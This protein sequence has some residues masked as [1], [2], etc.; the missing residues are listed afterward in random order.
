MPGQRARRLLCGLS[1]GAAGI[2][3]ALLELFAA[4]GD[5]RFAAAGHGAF[6]Y[7]SSWMDNQSGTWPDLRIGGQRRGGRRVPSPAIGTWCHGEGGIALTRL[8]A[9]HL[10]GDDTCRPDAEVALAT[11][12]EIADAVRRDIR[13]LSLCHGAAGSADVLVAGAEALGGRWAEAATLATQLGNTALAH[14]GV[15]GS[16][17]PCGPAAGTTPGLMRGLS[18][19]GWWFL[20]LHDRTVPSPLTMP[21]RTLTP[22]RYQA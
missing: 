15:P 3:W 22:S 4:T 19:I 12:D 16:D 21:V 7:E 8:R 13:D 17:W 20:R 5:E 11:T 1:H 10:L 14:Y 6:R 9:L 2:G 18:G